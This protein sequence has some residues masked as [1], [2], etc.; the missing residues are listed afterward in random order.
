MWC[1]QEVDASV[2]VARLKKENAELLARLRQVEAERDEA[3][4]LVAA[5]GGGGGGVGGAGSAAGS[6]PGG[7]SVTG[8]GA[9]SEVSDTTAAVPLEAKD[10]TDILGEC[11]KLVVPYLR[12][13][14]GTSTYRVAV[15]SWHVTSLWIGGGSSAECPLT[16]CQVF[17]GRICRSRPCQ[18]DETVARQ[19]WTF[20]FP[21]AMSKK[22][23]CAAPC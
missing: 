4:A 20:L 19:R 3:L 23:W 13:P 11:E 18:L 8:S 10:Y 15:D 12:A 6:R 2:V 7:G 14:M 17:P 5:G 1:A 9:S 22:A 21:Y 16:V